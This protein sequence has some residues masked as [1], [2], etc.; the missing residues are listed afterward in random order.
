MSTTMAVPLSLFLK[1]SASM[2]LKPSKGGSFKPY[3][4]A[5]GGLGEFRP[6]LTFGS[7]AAGIL[8]WRCPI[9]KLR[10]MLLMIELVAT[11]FIEKKN[12]VALYATQT[13]VQAGQKSQFEKNQARTAYLDFRFS[14]LHSPKIRQW[15]GK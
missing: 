4:L 6:E 7:L 8:G 9:G 2:G 10:L 11:W 3:I 12:E 5:G 1:P 14:P 13:E 15:R